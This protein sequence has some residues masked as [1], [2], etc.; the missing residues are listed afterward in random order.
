[1]ERIDP[2]VFCGSDAEK[3]LHRRL[4]AAFRSPEALNPPRYDAIFE[5]PT[6][7]LVE[8]RYGGETFAAYSLP[9]GNWVVDRDVEA[10]KNKF[11]KL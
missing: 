4:N 9:G 11:A 3:A 8:G 10:I 6:G 7:M 5:R 1:M 2:R